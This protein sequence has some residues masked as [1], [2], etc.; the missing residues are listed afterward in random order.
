V[1]VE[2]LIAR[3]PDPDS[4]PPCLLRLPIKGGLVFRTKGHPPPRPHGIPFTADPERAAVIAGSTT[5]PVTGLVQALNF[6]G[7]I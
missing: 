1:S 2:L 7:A 5:V 6:I 4:S 3:N